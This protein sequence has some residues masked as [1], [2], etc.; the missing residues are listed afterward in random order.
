MSERLR[1]PAV[2]RDHDELLA[3]ME[4][5]RTNDAR[6]REGR[7]FSLVYFAGE[8]HER[9]LQ[10]AHEKFF[11]E[12]ALNPMAFQSLKRMEA[13]VVQM[14]ASMLH[15]PPGAVGTMTSGGTESLLMAVKAYRERARAK[16]P[17][18]RTPEIV[19]PATIHVAVDKAAHYFGMRLR[20]ARVNADGTVDV[21]AMRRLINRNTVMLAASAPQY[22]HGV[23]DPIGEIGALA[24]EKG[25]PLHVDACIGGFM[26]PW[27]ERLG[28]P[29]APFDFRVPG[30][31]SISADLHKYGLAAKGASTVIYRDM[32]YL[33]HQFFAATDW[34]GGIYISPSAL[35]TRPG[36]TIAAAWAAMMGL[37]EEGYLHHT[38]LAMEATTRMI[39]GVRAI[40][41]LAV[42]GTPAGSIFAYRSVDRAVDL[43]AVA[44]LMAARGWHIDRQ[45][46][47]P[48]IH[49][50]VTSQHL[51]H[52][53]AYV[54]DLRACVAHVRSHPE[55]R[56][57]GNA[58]MYG[59]MAKVP[60]RAFIKQSVLKVMET[61]Y[62]PAGSN[63]DPMQSQNDGPV[64]AFVNRHADTVMGVLDRLESLRDRV[65]GGDR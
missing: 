19:A 64:M 58:A 16:W 37:G 32:S 23:L 31:T 28:Y 62:G 14:T 20:H 39:A 6:W 8:A 9:L 46:K 42:V 61:M 41:G 30:V 43:Y 60:V 48:T 47:P 29:I 59:M 7:C 63:N 38:R 45:Q 22:P 3:T 65:S 21:A 18:I 25:L 57:S 54:A 24:E 26:L 33:R 4:G 52:A 35:G 49:C 40:E 55:L 50:T 27:V 1:I 10:R 36:G 15:G 5:Y 44:D 51:D 2:P 34:P 12:N 11:M 13:E 53:D 17:W 56:A